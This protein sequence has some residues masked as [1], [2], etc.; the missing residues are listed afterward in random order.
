M[1]QRSPFLLLGDAATSSTSNKLRLCNEFSYR[2]LGALCD[3]N[4]RGQ[5]KCFWRNSHGIRI[6]LRH[7]R[8]LYSDASRGAQSEENL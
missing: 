2:P 4:V 6:K 8:C 7:F 1:S 3:E 5:L